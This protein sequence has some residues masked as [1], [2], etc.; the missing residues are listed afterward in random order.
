RSLGFRAYLSFGFALAIVVAVGASQFPK[1]GAQNTRARV[2]Q[3]L[4][5]IFMSH[6]E[7]SLDARAVADQVTSN[8]HVSLVTSL[9]DFELQLQPNDLRAPNYRAEQTD[10]DGVV[11]YTAM[12]GVTTYK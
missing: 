6:E 10:P 2:Q 11:R 1:A 3:D 8:G 7:L 4:A 9:H 12:P 5:Q